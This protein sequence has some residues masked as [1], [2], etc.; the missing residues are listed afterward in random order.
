M[1]LPSR[2]PLRIKIIRWLLRSPF[3]AAWIQSNKPSSSTN[4]YYLLN[5]SKLS[6]VT[7]LLD[8]STFSHIDW[9]RERECVFVFM[10]RTRILQIK[11]QIKLE[12]SRGITKVSTKPMRKGLCLNLNGNKNPKPQRTCLC[13]ITYGILPFHGMRFFY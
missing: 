8:A 11:E 9:C 10:Y 3:T 6:P 5:P 2:K 13:K 12:S 7:K 1:L 4:C